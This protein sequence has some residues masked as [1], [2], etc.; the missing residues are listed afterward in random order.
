MVVI[1]QE[2]AQGKEFAALLGGDE[3]AFLLSNKFAVAEGT[4]RGLEIAINRKIDGVMPPFRIGEL[5]AF[6]GAEGAS[7]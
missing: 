7:S 6:T 3:A 4:A 5:H 1:A 2:R